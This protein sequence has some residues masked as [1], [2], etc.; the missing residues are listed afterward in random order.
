MTLTWEEVGMCLLKTPLGWRKACEWKWKSL[1]R[2][3][4]FV[5]HGLYSP[6]NSPVQN[7]GVD[8]CLL[9]QGIFP[10]QGSNPSL[11]HCR[12]ILYQL[13]YQAWERRSQFH[14]GIPLLGPEREGMMADPRLQVA[15]LTTP[16]HLLGGRA[17]VGT[18]EAGRW[19]V[20][21]EVHP[22][23]QRQE[24]Q[25]IDALFTKSAFSDAVFCSAYAFHQFVWMETTYERHFKKIF[26]NYWRRES[27]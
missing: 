26:R 20:G 10:T 22:E 5:T 23:F 12:Q 8:S 17:P 3:R 19:A 1:S 21:L 7:T 25:M 16:S 27:F 24:D 14:L 4:L 11:L 6:W 9:I 18:Q 15:L 13:S 2:V